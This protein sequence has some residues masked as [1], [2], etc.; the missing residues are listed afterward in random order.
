VPLDWRKKTSGV[1]VSSVAETAVKGAAPEFR[2][3]T[4]IRNRSF[5]S[6]APLPLPPGPESSISALAC[7]TGSGV[8]TKSRMVVPSGA[9]TP[10]AMTALYPDASALTLYVPPG[11]RPV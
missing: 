5:G 6:R 7:R 4:V 9:T 8:R 11:K 1:S 10:M 3:D 2:S